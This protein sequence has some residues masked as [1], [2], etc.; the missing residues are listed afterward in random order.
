MLNGPTPTVEVPGQV[1]EPISASHQTTCHH[2]MGTG[3]NS[4]YIVSTITK[5]I[6]RS[7]SQRSRTSD[8]PD[9][10]EFSHKLD[11]SDSPN[12]LYHTMKALCYL[13]VDY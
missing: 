8:L 6:S 13:S 7:T 4:L 5:D 11:H 3:T 9:K 1:D 2:Y 12:Q 10:L